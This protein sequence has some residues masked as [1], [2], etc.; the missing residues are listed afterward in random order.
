[1]RRHVLRERLAVAVVAAAAAAAGTVAPPA[2]STE[3]RVAALVSQDAGPYQ[4]A[5]AG[6]RSS[7]ERQ[8]VKPGARVVAARGPATPAQGTARASSP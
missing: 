8:G 6:F 4:E 2:A 1:M 7:L 5:L 3:V